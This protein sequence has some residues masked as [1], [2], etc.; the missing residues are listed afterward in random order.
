MNWELRIK[1][2]CFMGF[3]SNSI[4]NHPIFKLISPG[5]AE[6]NSAWRLTLKTY[7][8]KLKT[9]LFARLFSKKQGDHYLQQAPFALPA[10][11]NWSAGFWNKKNF[12][13]IRWGICQPERLHSVKPA[14]ALCQ[15]GAVFVKAISGQSSQCAIRWIE[16]DRMG[17]HHSCRRLF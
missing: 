3:V 2:V 17:A 6:I 14:T 7:Y 4:Q 9:S 15:P 5:D 13:N 1:V 12:C 8:L 11:R 16:E 10:T